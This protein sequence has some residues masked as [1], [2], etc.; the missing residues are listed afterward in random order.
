MVPKMNQ[1]HRALNKLTIPGKFPMPII[2][3][4]LDELGEA[5]VFSKLDLKSRHHQIRMREE[6]VPKTAFHSSKLCPLAYPMP[7]QPSKH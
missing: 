6:D 7:L 4:L 2:A 3:E 1:G 5:K